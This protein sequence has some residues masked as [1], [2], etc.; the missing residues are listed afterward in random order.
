MII[1]QT[2]APPTIN[3]KYHYLSTLYENKESFEDKMIEIIDRKLQMFALEDAPLGDHNRDKFELSDF[4][5]SEADEYLSM[6]W[7][8]TIKLNKSM[9]KYVVKT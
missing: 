2:N 5:T 9:V 6:T 4:N 8:L 1:L 3:V 7:N